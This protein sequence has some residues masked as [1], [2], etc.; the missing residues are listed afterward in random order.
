M[1]TRREHDS[2]GER[3]VPAE[4][5][6]G[7][8]TVRS[9]RNFNAGGEVVPIE[10]IHAMALL[11]RACARA[12]HALGLLHDQKAT[13]IDAACESI[14]SGRFDDQFPID[15][16]QAGSGTSSN[17]N[18]NEVIANL[19]NEALGQPR[20]ERH[21]VHPN[22]DVN[23]GQSSNS[24]FPSAIR[25]AAVLLSK[26][27]L[28][29]IRLLITAL[30]AKALEFRNVVKSGRTHLQD[31]V[32]MT[33]GQA[34][35][36]WAHALRKD[37]VRIERAVETNLE[38]G[39]GGNAI[40]TGINT[41]PEF[42]ASIITDL[43]ALSGIPFR[44]AQNGIEMTQFLTDQAE[45]S[46]A[47]RLTAQDIGKIC[48][49]LRLLCSGPNTGLAEI[50]LPAVE[51][52]SSIMPGKINP[53]IVEAT[54][55]A[56]LQIMGHDHVVQLAS[57]AGQ[58]ELNTHMP[59]LGLNLVKAMQLMDRACDQLVDKCIVGI[60]AN[61]AN[62]YRHFEMSGALATILNPLLGYDRVSALVVEAIAQNKSTKQ[63]VVDKGILTAEEF[64]ALVWG[65]IR[66]NL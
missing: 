53:S 14:L 6:Y 39:E 8:H 4:A 38:L 66:S 11:K 45:L 29:S 9:L 30:E 64:E 18:L 10:I 37:V 15:I 24:T 46:S 1:S 32:P 51:P 7:I 55:M 25:V 42:R 43:S 56:M 33:L 61:I 23:M 2:L 58:L 31:A 3:E 16:F 36:A 35:S 40:G 19:A 49:D 54:N 28:R 21:P 50:D 17:M 47:L 12:N 65:S 26:S 13:V 57:A 59:V 63:I 22:D 48:N 52:G 5:L 44:I 27:M 34:F 60:T 62:C 41:K 20:G